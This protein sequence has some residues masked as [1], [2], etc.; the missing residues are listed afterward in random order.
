MTTTSVYLGLD[1]TDFIESGCTT[2]RM[3]HL[4]NYLIDQLSVIEQ[5]RRLVRLWPFAE[6]RTRGNGALGSI[7]KINSN[8]K[9]KLIEHCYSWFKEL[10][11]DINS[12]SNEL[13]QPSPCL[14]ISFTKFPEDWYW[15]SVRGHVDASFR[16][17]QLDL[18][19]CIIFTHNSDLGIVGASA[20]IAWIPSLTSSWELISWRRNE[21]IG[22]QR[23]VNFH[24]LSLMDRKFPETFVNRDP[25]RKK[26]L[27]APRTPC[28]VL[29]GI[30]GPSSASVTEAHIWLQSQNNTE[31]CLSYAVHISNQLSDDHISST[32][33][34][35]VVSEPS[36]T[37]GGHSY[38]DVISD[39]QL[40][41]IVA[42]REG[43]EVND[44]L[45]K[46]IPG[47]VISWTGIVSPDDSV[48]LEKLILIN[49]SPRID[50]RPYCCNRTMRS[51]GKNQELRCKI[52][53]K[54]TKKYWIYNNN[55]IQTNMWVEPSASNRRH[56]SKPLSISHPI[57]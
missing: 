49:P 3:N 35:T 6:N 24:N 7:I 23:E 53:E 31:K 48:H 2:E 27:I 44:L 41:R 40:S 21:L 11:N 50:R 42:F 29:Y 10:K 47:D 22:T 56:L 9:N 38:L 32:C 57:R 13:V 12:K 51:S 26:G 4:I 34:G 17:K 46:L 16:K 5:E 45:R 25:T 43:G 14:I 33:T 36:E 52:C 55:S 30:R 28:P 8:K 37:K 54:T 15:S 18:K 19:N 1:D 20:A 39:S